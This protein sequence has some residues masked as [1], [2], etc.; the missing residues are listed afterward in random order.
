MSKVS[1]IIETDNLRKPKLAIKSIAD[2]IRD[3]CG[4]VYIESP[5]GYL[6]KE[7]LK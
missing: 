6:Q 4:E 3:V 2:Y 1:F 5:E 7:D